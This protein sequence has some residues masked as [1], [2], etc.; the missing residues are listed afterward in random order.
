MS[1]QPKKPVTAYLPWFSVHSRFRPITSHDLLTHSS[2]LPGDR[3]DV[4]SALY[5]AYGV[6][7]RTTG[8]APGTHWAYSNIGYQ[9]L[10]YLLGRLEQRPS[11]EA[12]QRRIL[13]VP[14]PYLPRLGRS[15]VTG[16]IKGTAHAF[17]DLVKVMR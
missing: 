9:I 12:V 6:R 11:Y 3:D 1:N 15:K 14:V 16:T 10:G 4:P 8:S 7:D 13:E 2:G 17:S 5:Q